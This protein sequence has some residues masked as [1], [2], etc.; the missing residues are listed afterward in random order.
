MFSLIGDVICFHL[1]LF[2]VLEDS[3]RKQ[4]NKYKF[5]GT[6]CTTKKQ[7]QIYAVFTS[8]QTSLAYLYTALDRQVG[9]ITPSGTPTTAQGCAPT[10]AAGQHHRPHRSDFESFAPEIQ[11][12]DVF[13]M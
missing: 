8:S 7:V 11:S 9:C 12:T 4:E 5:W 2:L 13:Q 1:V 6:C 10:A 3:C